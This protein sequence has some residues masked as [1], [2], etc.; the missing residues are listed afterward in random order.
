MND[1]KT[2]IYIYG[3]HAVFEAL[4]N[5]PE[6]ISEIFILQNSDNAELKKIAAQKNIPVNVFHQSRL[7]GNVA[8]GSSHQGAVGLINLSK[9]IK[10]YDLFE[11]ELLVSEDTSLVLLDEVQD[12]QNVGAVIRS[13]AAF[14]ISAVLMPERN[15][16]PL[17]G[18]A[19]KASAGMAFKIPLISVGNVNQTIRKLKEKGF[20]I[21]GFSGR[22][23]HTVNKELF[24]LPSVFILG[25]ESSGIREKTEEL[26]DKLLSIPISSACDSLNVATAGSVAMYAWSAKHPRAI[27]ANGNLS[28]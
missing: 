8:A 27:L 13:A 17:T 9:I 5:Y 15:Q 23:R 21:Y 22:G 19:I 20:Y 18:S 25:N 1:S 24:D 3:K 28:S 14:G 11:K 12:P 26:C 4:A 6:A 7:P 16:A 2:K 10:H